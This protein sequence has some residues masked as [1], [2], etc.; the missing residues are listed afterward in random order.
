MIRHSISVYMNNTREFRDELLRRNSEDLKI[1]ISPFQDDEIS[2][3]LSCMSKGYYVNCLFL[4][5]K[6]Y[7]TPL[8]TD[9]DGRCKRRFKYKNYAHLSD[10][11]DDLIVYIDN[12]AT[13]RRTK[14]L[15]RFTQARDILATPNMPIPYNSSKISVAI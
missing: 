10:L 13:N 12:V 2:F 8:I 11:V 7:V 14:K 3:D 4:F 1:G 15:Y 9:R 6:D 5:Y